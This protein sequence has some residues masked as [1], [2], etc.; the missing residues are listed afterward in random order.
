MPGFLSKYAGTTTVNFDDGF[1]V[2]VRKSL[3]RGVSAD[4]RSLLMR[5]VMRIDQ[6]DDGESQKA[7]TTADVDTSA[8]Q[9]EIVYHSIVDWNLT[10]EGGQPLPLTPEAAK[11]ASIKILP[12]EVFDAIY[13][14][15]QGSPKRKPKGAADAEKARFPDAPVAGADG[16]G[17][18]VEPTA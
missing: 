4:A 6:N 18:G 10:D 8:F 14:A 3:P 7:T 12:D 13:E 16:P 17:D 11:R 15:C 2:T 1:W 9:D 5:P